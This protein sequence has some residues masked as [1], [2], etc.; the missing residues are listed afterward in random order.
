MNLKTT[1]RSISSEDLP[2]PGGHSSIPDKNFISSVRLMAPGMC[3]DT[4]REEER[5]M[6][7]NGR[8]L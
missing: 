7:R 5:R 2:F 1:E 8:V 6:I 4:K 3:V